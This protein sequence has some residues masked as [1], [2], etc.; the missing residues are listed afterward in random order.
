MNKFSL[1]FE[2]PKMEE[3][4]FKDQFEELFNF[5]TWACCLGTISAVCVFIMEF[6]FPFGFGFWKYAL[7]VIPLGFGLSHRLIKKFP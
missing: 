6:I 2:N 1:R 5:Y 7:I 3:L 4:Y